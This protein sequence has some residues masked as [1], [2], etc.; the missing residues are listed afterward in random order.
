MFNLL[1]MHF[2]FLSSS[3]AIL[4]YRDLKSAIKSYNFILSDFISRPF[5]PHVAMLQDWASSGV[6][7]V[8]KLIIS[9]TKLLDA[10]W[11]RGVQLFH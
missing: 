8:N 6:F 5:C 9:M 1:L 11:L 3:I 2:S 7:F 10:D 4:C